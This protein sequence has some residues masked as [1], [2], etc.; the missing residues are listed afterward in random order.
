MFVGVWLQRLCG[1]LQHQLIGIS[2]ESKS[3]KNKNGNTNL[4]TKSERLLNQKK[5]VS[6]R[7]TEKASPYSRK[8]IPAPTNLV[9]PK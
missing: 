4:G 3:N 8:H 5:G 2:S 9:L 7:I 6:A 1:A